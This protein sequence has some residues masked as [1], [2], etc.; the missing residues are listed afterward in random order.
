[1]L[2]SFAENAEIALDGQETSEM[3]KLEK[4]GYRFTPRLGAAW[5]RYRSLEFHFGVRS[6]N[7]VA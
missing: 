2:K 1:M 6:C 4:S 3:W 5:A 7:F